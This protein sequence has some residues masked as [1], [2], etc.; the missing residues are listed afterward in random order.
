MFSR[1]RK[2]I[3]Y[4]NVAM[5]L[6]LVFAMTGGAYAAKRYLITSTKQIKPSVIAQLK[7][8]TGPAG[9]AGK[10]GANGLNGKDGAQGPQGPHGPKG[11]TGEKGK[12]GVSVTS[13]SV[14]TSS[15]TCSKL[16]GSE[17]T[18]S[19]GK[20]T[21]CNGKEGPTGPTGATGPQGPL[22]SGKTETGGWAVSAHV[23]G[24]IFQAVSLA[25]PLTA[26]LEEEDIFFI[27]PGQAGKEFATQCPGT[28]EAPAAAKGDLCVYAQ[29][30][31]GSLEF[32]GFGATWDSGVVMAFNATKEEKAP[33]ASVGFGTWAVTA[34]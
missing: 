28:V 3:T 24:T 34:S 26:P 31:I 23:E 19:N 14:Q 20:T 9:L 5:T 32:Q 10:D 29:A 8:K 27:K 4:A 12:D 30:L 7:G 17:F 1:I 22:Q 18:A 25:L 33:F 11:D 13:A 21:A 16:G 6:A 15:A 2:R